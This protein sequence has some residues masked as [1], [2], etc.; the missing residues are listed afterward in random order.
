MKKRNLI[1]ILS[2]FV[3]IAAISGII[4]ATSVNRSNTSKA[5]TNALSSIQGVKYAQFEVQHPGVTT[6]N[7]ILVFVVID[8]DSKTQVAS[9]I[10]GVERAT[11]E[12]K[13]ASTYTLH[14]YFRSS[15]DLN[16]LTVKGMDEDK[17]RN[18][19]FNKSLN[20]EE[21]AIL[22]EVIGSNKEIRRT[23]NELTVSSSYIKEKHQ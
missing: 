2:I 18:L 13:I 23:D 22:D 10:D 4:I 9:A 1:I 12:A 7:S 21:E 8:I 15:K 11:H 16:P 6:N 19:F 5:Y 3:V 20:T 14:M 17:R